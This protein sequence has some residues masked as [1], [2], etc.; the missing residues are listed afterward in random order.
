MRIAV[1]A[2]MHESNTFIVAPTTLADYSIHRGAALVDYYGPTFHEVGGMIQG[3]NDFGFELVPM[4]AANATPKGAL[5]SETYE[6]IL[7]EILEQIRAEL[8]N[9]DGILLA[10]HGAM[11]VE[12]IP[13]GDGETVRRVRELVGPDFPVV[14]TH[15]YHGNVPPQLVNDATALIIY[16]TCPHIDQRERGIQAAELLV[17]TIK[18]EIQ[19]TGAIVKP[20]LVY[21]IMFHNTSAPPMQPLMEAAIA[22]EDKPGIVAVSIAAGYQY[23][24]VPWMGPSIVVVADGDQA[25]AEREAQ[26]LADMMWD[27]REQLILDVPD[28]AAAVKTAME[29]E[30]APIALFEVGDNIG[31]GSAGDATILLEQLLAQEAKNWVVAIYDPEMVQAC[32]DAGIGAAVDLQVGGKTD[33]QHGATLSISGTVKNL[34]DGKYEETERR[35]GGARFIDQGQT[36]VVAVNDGLLILNS[37]RTTPFSIHQLTSVGIVPEDQKILVAKGTVAPRAAYEPVCARIIEVDTAGAT[38]INQPAS[39]YQLAR[40]DLY[41]WRVNGGE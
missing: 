27:A 19:P 25:L 34:H 15:D 12:G 17:R 10:L 3:S 20:N 37:K 23:A 30:E 11:V 24:D 9:L 8:P 38:A 7:G 35:H 39:A 21:N 2:F 31:G 6:T 13:H 4:L 32:V 1:A 29:S 14:V 5:T 36:A 28:A 16:K 18:G 22:L 26:T 40:K 41:E 33:E